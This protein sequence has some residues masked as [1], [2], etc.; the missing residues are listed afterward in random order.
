MPHSFE[1]FLRK[2]IDDKKKR[3]EGTNLNPRGT[4]GT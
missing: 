3:Q 2:V 1:G 4:L